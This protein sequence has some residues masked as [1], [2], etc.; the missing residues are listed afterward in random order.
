VQVPAQA[1]GDPRALGHQIV[2]V[3]H[4]EVNLPL[5]AREDGRGQIRMGKRRAGD[6]EGVDRIGLAARAARAARLAHQA[7]RHPP[8]ADAALE[9]QPLEPSGD[10]SAVLEREEDLLVERQR[11]AQDPLVAVPARGDRALAQ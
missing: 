2:A 6:G 7:R 4:Q 1:L 10:V 3:A 9:Q 8:H 11:P 5:R